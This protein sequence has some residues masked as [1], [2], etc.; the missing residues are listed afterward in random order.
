MLFIR[1]LVTIENCNTMTLEKYTP[2]NFIGT[3]SAIFTTLIAT[4]T[5]G[6]YWIYDFNLPLDLQGESLYYGSFYLS[7]D[8]ILKIMPTILLL[9][10]IIKLPFY[11]HHFFESANTKKKRKFGK[12][13]KWI[14]KNLTRLIPIINFLV[15]I[16][17]VSFP[18][19][20]IRVSTLVLYISLFTCF[21]S[22]EWKKIKSVQYISIASFAL[23]IAVQ[24]ETLEKMKTLY[25]T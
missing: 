5:L 18:T 20:E 9:V 25:G 11:T 6:I 23:I 16:T 1:L 4:W 19:F 17:L 8:C 15:I 12:N 3:I 22:L 24:F 14:K 13:I 2:I 7:I 21:H 10:A